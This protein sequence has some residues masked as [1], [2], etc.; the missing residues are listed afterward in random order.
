M[1]L[2]N[3]AF[4][5]FFPLA[6]FACVFICLFIS[7]ESIAKEKNNVTLCGHLV[8]RFGNGFPLSHA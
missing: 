6:L 8:A 1:S 5:V 3:S 7:T 4:S 2:A